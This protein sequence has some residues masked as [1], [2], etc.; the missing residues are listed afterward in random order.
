M[1]LQADHHVLEGELVSPD[2]PRGLSRGGRPDLASAEALS[3]VRAHTLLLVGGADTEVLSLNRGAQAVIGAR[4][5]LVVV[6]GATHLFEEP[7]ALARVATTCA[8]WLVRVFPQ[9]RLRSA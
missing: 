2:R 7:G 9:A 5:E 1:P 8:Q 6:P 4:A 3:R